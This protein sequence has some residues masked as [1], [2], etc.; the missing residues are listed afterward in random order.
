MNRRITLWGGKEFSFPLLFLFR[1]ALALISLCLLFVVVS[2]C[3]GSDSNATAVP[4]DTPLRIG[5]IPTRGVLPLAVAETMGYYEHE[6]LSVE[7]VSFQS[8]AEKD[9]AFQSG[10]IDGMF[11]DLVATTLLSAHGEGLKVVAMVA[12]GASNEGRVAIVAA[13]NSSIARAEDLR[14][15]DLALSRNTILD[16]ATDELLSEV[17]LDEGVTRIPVGKVHL[18]LHMLLESKVSAAMLPEPLIT[19]AQTQGARVILDDQK[20]G[21]CFLVLAFRQGVINHRTEA[22][23]RFLIAYNRAVDDINCSPQQ[24]RDALITVAR[25]PRGIHEVVRVTRYAHWRVP[26]RKQVDRVTEWLQRRA[27]VSDNIGYRGL[28]DDRFVHNEDMRCIKIWKNEQ[29]ARVR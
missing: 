12:G 25:V 15:H 16:F 26:T 19:Y 3:G 18:R 13:P 24:H 17:G 27:L 9:A 11:S 28:I 23:E 4:L 22:V 8:T 21:R 29:L 1:G 2:G 6:G 20:D 14:G 5:I 7:L 10:A